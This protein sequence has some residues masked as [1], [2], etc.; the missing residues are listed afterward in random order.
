MIRP[1]LRYLRAMMLGDTY[2]IDCVSTLVV[3]AVS[4]SMWAL[5]VHT[6]VTQGVLG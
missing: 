6:V 3:G 1:V 5:N 4:A 2:N